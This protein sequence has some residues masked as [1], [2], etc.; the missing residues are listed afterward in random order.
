M[1]KEVFLVM[2]GKTGLDKNKTMWGP[3]VPPYSHFHPL[4]VFLSDGTRA[5]KRRPQYLL[6]IHFQVHTFDSMFSS[7]DCCIRVK[8]VH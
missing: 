4:L 8:S 7:L 6:F 3:L 2:W 1:G 5:E